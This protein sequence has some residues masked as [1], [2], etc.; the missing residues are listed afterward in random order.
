MAACKLASKGKT[1]ADSTYEAEVQALQSFL[2]MQH[3]VVSPTHNN[4]HNSNNV[5]INLEI[6]P[7]DYVAARFFKKIKSKSVSGLLTTT[8][9]V[10]LAPNVVRLVFSIFCP[11]LIQIRVNSD[12]PDMNLGFFFSLSFFV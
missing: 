1:M 8:R 12:V 4:S 5:S 10:G 11:N 2:G 7:E 6:Q 3:P 9:D